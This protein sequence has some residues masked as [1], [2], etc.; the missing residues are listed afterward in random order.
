VLALDVVGYRVSAANDWWGRAGGPGP[1]RTLVA[2]A[3]DTRGP[4]SAPPASCT[5][6]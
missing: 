1:G 3:L 2:G 5:H 6:R 4:L